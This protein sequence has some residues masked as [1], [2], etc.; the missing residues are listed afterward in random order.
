MNIQVITELYDAGTTEDGQVFAAERFI[1]QA[2]AADGSRL[3]HYVFFNGCDPR[4]DP[5]DGHVAFVDIREEARAEAEKLAARITAALAAG[6]KLDMA[7]WGEV[8]PCYGSKAYIK[9]NWEAR[10]AHE[11]REQG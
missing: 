4:R 7:Y 10:R 11:E 6:G 9:G 8:Q 5:E 2:E 3:N 1:V